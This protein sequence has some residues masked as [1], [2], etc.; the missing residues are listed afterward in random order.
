MAIFK[1]CRRRKCNITKLLQRPSC[2]VGFNVAKFSR[3]VNGT[4]L[5]RDKRGKDKEDECCENDNVRSHLGWHKLP[6][7][8]K[9]KERSQK[10]EAKR[11][12]ELLIERKHNK[13]KLKIPKKVWSS[14]STRSKL[15][16]VTKHPICNQEKNNLFG[17]FFPLKAVM[18]Q[19]LILI[20]IILLLILRNTAKYA[21]RVIHVVLMLVMWDRVFVVNASFCGKCNHWILYK[22][23]AQNN[24]W[25]TV[26]DHCNNVSDCQKA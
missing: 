26:I 5:S 12:R 14:S 4:L 23:S 19:I 20:L 10:E 22:C 2:W 25:S 15:A 16:P 11:E 21:E 9:K 7:S 6:K 13:K 17:K 18:N 8:G 1:S 3:C 24:G